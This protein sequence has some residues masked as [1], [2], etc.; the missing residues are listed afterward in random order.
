[1][2]NLPFNMRT[3]SSSA[4][5]ASTTS[6]KSFIRPTMSPMPRMRDANPSGRISSSLSSDSPIPKNLMGLP[7]TSLIESAAPP[8]ASP[9]SLVRMTPVTPTRSLKVLAVLTASW[10]IMASMTKKTSLGFVRFLMSSS[11]CMSGSSIAN[12]PAVS[13]RTTSRFDS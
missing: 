1:M 3:A 5:S 8:R 10:P 2:S 12:R 7:V 6:S 13:N 11:S 9:S 4:F